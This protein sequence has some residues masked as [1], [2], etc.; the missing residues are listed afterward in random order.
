MHTT[1][2]RTTARP[3]L[4]SRA[5]LAKDT[6]S[7]PLRAVTLFEDDRWGL[8]SLRTE[9]CSSAAG[10]A[11]TGA[12]STSSLTTGSAPSTWWTT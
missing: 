9:R 5:Q 12:G 4:R 6:L 2:S 7:F 3:L 8:S 11:A 10:S 1:S